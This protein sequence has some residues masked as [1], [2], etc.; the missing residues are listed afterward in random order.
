M[1]NISIRKEN[2]NRNAPA[3]QTWE[4]R[5]E[6]FRMIRDMMGWDPFREMVPYVSPLPAGFIPS[7]D[8]KETKEGYLFKADVPGVKEG[9]ID[10][11]VTGN[12]LTISGKRDGEKEEHTDTYYAYERNY[13]N[14]TRSFTLPDGVDMNSVY[15]DLKD[16]VLTLSLK[17][18]PELQPKK[19]PVMSASKKS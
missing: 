18:L 9:D 11:I 19:V 8:I 3:L 1:A 16:G 14:F 4:P 12:R 5:W 6:P 17:R 15:A 7:F 13:G 2:E 10:V